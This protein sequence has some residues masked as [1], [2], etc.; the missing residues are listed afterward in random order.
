MIFSNVCVV[1]CQSAHRSSVVPAVVGSRSPRHTGSSSRGRGADRPENNNN[2]TKTMVFPI[3]KSRSKHTGQKDRC[4][5]HRIDK[6]NP[7]SAVCCW[8]RGVQS[9]NGSVGRFRARQRSKSSPDVWLRSGWLVVCLVS[10]RDRGSIHRRRRR[11]CRRCET[12]EPLPILPCRC[13]CCAWPTVPAS[14]G[15]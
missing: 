12:T 10:A 3:R 7:T 4:E 14:G 13:C 11:C 8:C 5:G 6:K 15:G 1:E 9:V 2:N